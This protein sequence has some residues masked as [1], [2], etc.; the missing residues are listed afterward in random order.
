MKKLTIVLAVLGLVFAGS[1]NDF[2]MAGEVDILI[3][4]L[5]E[6]GIL[7]Q[8][9]AKQLIMEMQKES[10]RQEDA[11][12]RLASETATETVQKETKAVESKIP[13]WVQNTT[14]K[15]DFRLRYQHEQR[16]DSGK[17]DRDR[18]RFRW[19]MDADSKINDEWKAG[20]RSTAMTPTTPG[21]SWFS[22]GSIGA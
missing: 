5:V 14:F 22:P 10:A 18:F 21:C 4:K 2:A 15:A 9:D 7:N 17:P 20:W 16:D 13:K 1:M 8:S 12:K 11:V 19:R 3:N 6:K